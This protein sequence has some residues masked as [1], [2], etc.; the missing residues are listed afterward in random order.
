[1]GGGGRLASLISPLKVF[2]R[3]R[4]GNTDLKI[5]AEIELLQTDTKKKWTR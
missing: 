4:N 2:A 5:S 1:M 3:N